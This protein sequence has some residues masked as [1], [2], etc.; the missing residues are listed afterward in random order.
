MMMFIFF[1]PTADCCKV[2]TIF[3]DCRS[4]HQ[5]YENIYIIALMLLLSF[6]RATS[7]EKEHRRFQQQ[8]QQ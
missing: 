5:D 4:Y 6:F 8:N 2:E 7:K 1:I 3:I